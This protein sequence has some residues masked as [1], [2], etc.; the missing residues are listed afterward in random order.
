V[1]LF[2]RLLIACSNLGATQLDLTGSANLSTNEANSLFIDKK[3]IS[4]PVL[5]QAFSVALTSA[6]YGPSVSNLEHLSL[7]RL[8]CKRSP[9]CNC[10]ADRPNTPGYSELG[11]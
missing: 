3:T 11:N 1:I 2:V 9:T 8:V 6:S 7:N 10:Y 4:P 5:L